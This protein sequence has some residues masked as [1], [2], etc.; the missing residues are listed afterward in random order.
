ME[1][2]SLVE[3]RQGNELLQPNVLSALT[4]QFEQRA[5]GQKNVGWTLLEGPGGSKGQRD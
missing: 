2:L 1:M 3:D 5:L 4:F